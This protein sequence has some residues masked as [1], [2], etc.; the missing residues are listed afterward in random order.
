M[1]RWRNGAKNQAVKDVGALWDALEEI[2]AAPDRW[3]LRPDLYPGC[4]ARICGRHLIIYRTRE[5]RVEISRI[6]HGAM[7]LRDHIPRDFLGGE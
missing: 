2:A 3:R 5:N 4:R 7:N 1:T 6:L